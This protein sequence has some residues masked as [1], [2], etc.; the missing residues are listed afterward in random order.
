MTVAQNIQ[1]RD[2]NREKPQEL[3]TQL[4]LK[5]GY[6]NTINKLQTILNEGE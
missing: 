2:I 5:F 3:L 6:E 4:I 1:T